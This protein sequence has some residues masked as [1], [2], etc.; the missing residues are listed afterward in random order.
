MTTACTI[1][2]EAQVDLILAFTK[3]GKLARDLSKF[4]ME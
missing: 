4:R 3:T 2:S 1:A